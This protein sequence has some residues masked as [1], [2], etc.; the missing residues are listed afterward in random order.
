M[1]G[2]G[3]ITGISQ[4]ALYSMSAVACRELEKTNVRFNEAYLDYRVEYDEQCDGEGNEWK[5][6]SSD[7][8]K[9]YEQIL[10]QK[11]IEACRVI[12]E[13]PK[14]LKK[15]RYEKKLAGLNGANT[16]GQ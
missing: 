3:G 1:Q 2:I 10:T 12:T 5:M 16:W 8:A 7:Y 9:I 13:S 4:G 14:D 6:R 15:I 11:D